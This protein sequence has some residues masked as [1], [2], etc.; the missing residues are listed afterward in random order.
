MQNSHR[1]SLNHRKKAGWLGE[2]EYTENGQRR[3]GGAGV[4]DDMEPC[5]S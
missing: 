4:G 2:S 5:G 1:V 3:A